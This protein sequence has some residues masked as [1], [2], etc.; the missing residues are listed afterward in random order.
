MRSWT[1]PTLP[2]LPP[3][4]EP[5]PAAVRVRRSEDADL[6][7]VGGPER[8]S[9]YVCGITPYDATHLGHA[10]T[11]LTFDLLNRAWRD[12]GVEVTYAQNVTDVDDPLLERARATG[13]DWRDLAHSQIDLFRGDMAA[14]RILPPEHYLGA[15]E[16]V[17][18]V[19]RTVSRLL[20]DG[21]A[22]RVPADAEGQGEG[23]V[24]ADLGADS[25]FGETSLDEDARTAAARSAQ[26]G[27]RGGDPD[28]P[29]KRSPLDP[30]LWRRAREGEPSWPGDDLGAG[31]PGWHVECAT[32][33]AM[34]LGAPLTVC[35]G[36]SDL[37]FPHHEMSASHLR[38]LTGVAAPVAAHL[39]VGLVGYQGHKMSKSRGNLVLVSRL[40]DQGADP[41]AIRLALLAHHYAQPWEFTEGELI[42]ASERLA[43][44]REAVRVP[45]ASG[46]QA[47]LTQVREALADDLDAPRALHAVD[48]WA[49]AVVR[50]PQA[51][52]AQREADLVAATVDALLG[53]RLDLPEPG[54]RAS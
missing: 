43:L 32:I 2:T 39:H 27:E 15:V 6:R 8:A 5:T 51:P 20:A 16:T 10:F 48:A 52:D 1:A 7:A 37:R 11:Y 9:L 17:P 36:G 42:D 40:R 19:V 54:A 18:D 31:R 29:G 12:A 13:V 25:R 23:D 21:S 46:A 41:M 47:V 34:T 4:S 26:F 45:G 22:Y 28:R 30:L 35:G 38:M 3:E 53:V 44:W 49:R 33:A 24:Y 50:A 14:L